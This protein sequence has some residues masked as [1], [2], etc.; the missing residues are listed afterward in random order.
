MAK[1]RVKVTLK[2]APRDPPDVLTSD[3]PIEADYHFMGKKEVLREWSSTTTRI[4]DD[5]TPYLPDKEPYHHYEPIKTGQ[6][7]TRKHLQM[8]FLREKMEA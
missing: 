3:R 7:N 5:I 1:Q 6:F 4:H 2:P 8:N